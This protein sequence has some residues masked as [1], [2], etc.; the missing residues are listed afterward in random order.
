MGQQPP[1]VKG[2]TPP[3]PGKRDASTSQT[4]LACS[5]GRL[6]EST[7]SPAAPL[8]TARAHS[9][10]P[11]MLPAKGPTLHHM[12]CAYRP[13]KQKLQPTVTVNMPCQ[14]LQLQNCSKYLHTTAG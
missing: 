12:Q 6:R 9:C 5:T 7:E 3:V 14:T 1:M 4:M 13:S 10:K 11:G 2:I 8:L